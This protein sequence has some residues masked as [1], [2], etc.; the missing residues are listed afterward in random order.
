MILTTL[1]EP[2][3]LRPLL[4][5]SKAL[6]GY[7]VHAAF[8]RYFDVLGANVQRWHARG[9]ILNLLQPSTSL[10][11]PEPFDLDAIDLESLTELLGTYFYL[12]VGHKSVNRIL[13]QPYT[14]KRLLYLRGYDF[15][16]T[17]Y[18]GEGLASEARSVDTQRFTNKLEK[19]ASHDLCLLKVMSPDEVYWE[20][21]GLGKLFLKPDLNPVIQK[22]N[23]PVRSAYMNA[24]TWKQ[25]LLPLLDR[26]DYFVVYV[27]S[28][29][30]ST[31][32][33]LEQLDTPERRARVT[34]V[35]DTQAIA[36][37]GGILAAQENARSDGQ[38]LIW[39]KSGSEPGFTPEEFRSRLARTFLVVSPEEFEGDIEMHRSRIRQSSAADAPGANA[40][41]IEFEFYPALPADALA[42]LR[43]F[44]AWIKTRITSAIE[45]QSI[46]SLLLFLNDVQFCIYT[47]LLLGEHDET[48]RALAMYAATLKCC[49]HLAYLEDHAYAAAYWGISLLACGKSHEFDSIYDRAKTEFEEIQRNAGAAVTRFLEKNAERQPGFPLPVIP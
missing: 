37:K 8:K 44:C 11:S 40:E 31:L 7:R 14:G 10:A 3:D 46:E 49:E 28:L 24:L 27:S 12:F 1:S 45:Q 22:A 35:F 6:L 23:Y 4:D 26:A 5:A 42:S 33:E 47:T 29:T 15:T 16:F 2:P 17:Q 20:T 19:L 34:V 43:E 25:G 32:W 21:L 30:P 41:W 39:S 38:D 36:N 13:M 9:L 18:F 48:A